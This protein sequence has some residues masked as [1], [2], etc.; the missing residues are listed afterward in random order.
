[1]Y[2]FLIIL[3]YNISRL[4]LII[5]AYNI[6]RHLATKCM[7]NFPDHLICTF[8]GT[9]ID[10]SVRCVLNMTFSSLCLEIHV[11]TL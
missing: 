3:A 5:L 4:F 8:Y 2:E 11:L 9:K 7:R 1:M 10:A 6:S